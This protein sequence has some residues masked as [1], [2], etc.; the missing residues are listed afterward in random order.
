MY[1]AHV[2]CIIFYEIKNTVSSLF[3]INFTRFVIKYILVKPFEI[4]TIT[5]SLQ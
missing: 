5:L 4:E 1:N 3:K 2:S